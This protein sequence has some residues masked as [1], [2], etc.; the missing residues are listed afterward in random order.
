[1]D[2]NDDVIFKEVRTGSTPNKIVFIIG[3]GYEADNII[4]WDM[5]KDLE[6]ESYEIDEDY[7]VIW[8]INGNPYV[9]TEGK[10][11]FP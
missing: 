10:A 8:D 5:I 9:I 11:I 4:I 3:N 2:P 1:M 7:L 6:G